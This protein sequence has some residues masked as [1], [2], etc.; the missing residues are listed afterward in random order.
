MSKIY[1]DHSATTPVDKRVLEAMLPYFSEKFGNASSVHSFGQE[2]MAAVDQAREKIA[3]YFNC[4]FTE[5]IFTG[6]ATEANNLALKG[7][8]LLLPNYAI[9]ENGNDYNKLHIISTKIEH[10]SVLEPLKELERAG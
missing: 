7:L 4:D 8:A 10:E 3:R 6:S 2:A 1:F 9:A 5:I